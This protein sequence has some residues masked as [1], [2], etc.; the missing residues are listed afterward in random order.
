MIKISFDEFKKEFE[1]FKKGVSSK[2]IDIDEA[3]F[4]ISTN[5]IYNLETIDMLSNRI[6]LT[7]EQMKQF[8]KIKTEVKD[9]QDYL[10]EEKEQLETQV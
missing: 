9:F 8:N 6:S 4:V 2:K 1:F 7:P 3:L 10:I 5:F